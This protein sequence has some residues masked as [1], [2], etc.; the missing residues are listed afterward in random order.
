MMA[1][2]TAA[3]LGSEVSI[4]EQ[5]EKLGKK[6]F[7]TGKGRCNLTNASDR[8]THLAA[9][10]SGA[11]FLYSSQTRFDAAATMEFFE[12][13]G[14][15]LKTER[16][17]RVFP[18]SDHSSDVIRAL[19]YELKRLGVRIFL[20]TPVKE[21]LTEEISGEELSVEELTREDTTKEEKKK[22]SGKKSSKCIGKIT[23]IRLSDGS[24]VMADKVILATGGISYPLTGADGSGL[25]MAERSGHTVT[26]LYP[27]L[28]PLTV[29]EPWIS[30]L[31]GLSLRNVSVLIREG[32]KKLYEGFGEMLFTHRG[33]S[34]PLI[35][36]ASSYVTTHFEPSGKGGD[37]AE[38]LLLQI[39]LKPALDE[40]T[41]DRRLIRELEEAKTKQVKNMMGS[42][43]PS[44]MIPVVLDMAGI[45]AEEK[46][47][48]VNKQQRRALLQTLKSFSLT[49]NGTEGF[50][51]AIITKG[52]VKT[53]QIDPATMASKLVKGLYFA[54]ECVDVDALTGGFN[55]QIAWASGYAA[56]NA[57]ATEGEKI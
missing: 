51:Q 26:K 18:A 27:A 50:D 4:Y 28:V 29:A 48:E 43:L 41:L 22:S 25:A 53:G 12:Q 17:Q 57:A 19:E 33:V 6:L 49:I 20:N 56:G 24:K 15:S 13:L 11:R 52:G 47:C 7:I 8:D 23:G 45:P 38:K 34:G 46:A 42:L 55:L 44:G 37:Q 16:G 9:V 30:Q 39:D 36:S 21:L 54:G 5:N 10:V 35:L 14:V 3:R 31:A 2:V 32:K 40:E 1:A